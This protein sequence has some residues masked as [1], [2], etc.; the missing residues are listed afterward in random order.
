MYKNI[1]KIKLKNLKKMFYRIKKIKLAERVDLMLIALTTKGK[2][3]F[4]RG[5]QEETFGGHG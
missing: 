2:S 4:L 3:I 5:G 1:N